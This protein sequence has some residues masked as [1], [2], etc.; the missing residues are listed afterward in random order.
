MSQ[1]DPVAVT[2]T[3]SYVGHGGNARNGRYFYNY[4]PDFVQ[5]DDKDTAITYALDSKSATRFSIY[6]YALCDPTNQMYDVNLE[7]G[8]LSMM[9]HCSEENQVIILSILVKDNETGVIIDCDP[10]VTNVPPPD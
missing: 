3:V 8:V 9:D 2:L 7:G 10:Q 1:N 6:S 4:T 5:V